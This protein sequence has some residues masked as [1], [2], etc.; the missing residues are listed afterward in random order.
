MPILIA[1]AAGAAAT[2]GAYRG[3][4]AAVQDA[5]RKRIARR[6][7]K[8]QREAEEAEAIM[9]K[10]QAQAQKDEAAALSVE[11]RL[12]RYKQGAA[13]YDPTNSTKKKKGLLG[14]LRKKGQAE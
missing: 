12:A 11:E 5:K 4:K 6:S 9:R 14:R 10:Q 8:E 13:T 3:G 1:T 2:Y 7:M